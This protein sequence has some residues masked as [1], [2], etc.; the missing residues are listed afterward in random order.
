MGD[1]IT[2]SIWIN[3]PREALFQHF[4]EAEKV[5]GWSG[6]AAR[7]EPV[8]G[9]LYELDMGE[10]GLF[11]GRF[12]TV[13]RPESVIYE[14]DPPPGMNVPPS[15]VEISLAEEG[16]GTRVTVRHTGIPGPFADV[17]GRGWDH[18]LARLSVLVQGG[19]PG[20]DALCAC[21]LPA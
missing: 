14:V 11:R 20:A 12:I 10:A 2:R 17:A 16:G 13:D 21:P 7:M 18:H 8:P 9:G 1:P 5:A 3:A 15:R 19:A 4:I 6:R